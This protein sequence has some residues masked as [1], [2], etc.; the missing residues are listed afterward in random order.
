MLENVLFAFLPIGVLMGGV[1]FF[2]RLSSHTFL[3][4]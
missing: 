2:I 1:N 3:F 4:C